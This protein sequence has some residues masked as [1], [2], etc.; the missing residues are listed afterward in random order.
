LAHPVQTNSK[1]KGKHSISTTIFPSEP[2]LAGTPECL[3]SGFY[4]S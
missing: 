1:Q 4:S 2:G 3:H